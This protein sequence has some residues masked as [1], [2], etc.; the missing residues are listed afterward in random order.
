MDFSEHLIISA[1]GSAA[2]LAA[3]GD[4]KSAAAFAATGVFVDLDH[5]VDY[6]RETGLNW[7][8]P[9]FLGYFSRRQV[10]RLVLPLHAWEGVLLGWGLS[11]AL[12]SPAWVD[13]AFFGWLQH[14]L[15]D[16]RFNGLHKMAYFFSFRVKQGFKV[17]K[18]YG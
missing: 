5:F 6:W 11:L 17:E 2:I 1:A 12:G 7:N 14:L 8:L 9:R 3:G 16:Q 13:W 15:L 18:L 10:R 4:P